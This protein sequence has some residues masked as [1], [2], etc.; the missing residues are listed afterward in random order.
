[1]FPLEAW[2]CC[3][4]RL[5]QWFFFRQFKPFFDFASSVRGSCLQPWEHGLSWLMVGLFLAQANSNPSSGHSH[6]SDVSG[7][8]GTINLRRSRSDCRMPPVR[9]KWWIVGRKPSI[10]SVEQVMNKWWTGDERMAWMDWM[11]GLGCKVRGD[12]RPAARITRLILV[13]LAV[14]KATRSQEWSKRHEAKGPG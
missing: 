9:T 1:M 6:G 5:F 10:N 8:S 3:M 2:P 14:T 4:F 11:D 13:P 7:I 12:L